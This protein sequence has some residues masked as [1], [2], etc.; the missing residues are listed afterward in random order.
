MRSAPIRAAARVFQTAAKK[1][2]TTARVKGFNPPLT[3][4]LLVRVSR[5]VRL[6]TIMLKSSA[7]T[8]KRKENQVDTA[9]ALTNLMIQSPFGL[10]GLPARVHVRAPKET[11]DG[12]T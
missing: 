9:Q 2:T 10:H 11:P 6:A 8:L 12:G 4:P 1:D 7:T 3:F 5:L